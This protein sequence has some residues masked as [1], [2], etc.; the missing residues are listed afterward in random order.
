LPVTAG[1]ILLGKL[2]SRFVVG[3]VQMI[4]LFAVGY[5]LFDIS[6]PSRGRCCCRS[7]A[8][9][10]RHGVRASRCSRARAAR[11]YRSARLR[12]TMAAIGGCW[13]RST[14]SHGCQRRS[15]SDDLGDGA[16]NDL[17]IRRRARGR[18]PTAVLLAYGLATSPSVSLCSAGDRAS[19]LDGA[20]RPAAKC[21]R[22]CLRMSM[23]LMSG[24]ALPQRH[25][26]AER[27]R[28][29]N[30]IS[31]SGVARAAF[32]VV[33]SHSGHIK[34]SWAASTRVPRAA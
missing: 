9:L 22:C 28:I 20:E 16:F 30:A 5:V 26:S 8:S 17:M 24:A 27:E 3:L 12:S 33:E 23:G 6:D 11:C 32:G 4:V 10:R 25:T 19:A 34:S 14:S 13:W 31:R 2:L 21:P 1:N 7:S 29:V 18:V 15:R